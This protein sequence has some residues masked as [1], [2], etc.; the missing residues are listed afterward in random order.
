MGLQGHYEFLMVIGLGV[1]CSRLNTLSLTF[2]HDHPACMPE[3]SEN[4]ST[5]CTLSAR[6]KAL[7]TET[8]QERSI[9]RFRVD[10]GERGGRLVVYQALLW[11][12][13]V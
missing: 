2:S 7:S 12:W 13:T 4:G 8:R 6:L 9:S 11:G 5:E 1:V 3:R 10:F